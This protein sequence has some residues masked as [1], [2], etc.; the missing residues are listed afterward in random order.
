MSALVVVAHPDPESLTHGV[1]QQISRSLTGDG[2]ENRVADLHAEQF[3]PRFTLADRRRYQGNGPIPADV[4]AEQ[5]RLDGVDDI[6]L[7]F[8]VYWWSMPALLKGWIDRVFVNGWAFDDHSTPLVGK[9]GHKTIHLVLLAGDD[10]DSFRR[11]GYDTAITTQIETGVLGYCGARTGITA[12]V[13]ESESR[14]SAS[15]E[16]EVSAVAASVAD[17]VRRTRRPIGV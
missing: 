5:E 10:A 17:E 12:V 11:H 3:D 14:S 15:I 4:A 16:Q 9:L 1:G 13:H 8:P 2:V 6:V 7:V